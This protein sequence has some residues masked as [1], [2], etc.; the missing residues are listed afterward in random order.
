MSPPSRRSGFQSIMLGLLL[1]MA[2]SASVVAAAEL[3]TRIA[4]PSGMN[5]QIVVTMDK[6][7]IAK[8]NGLY[9]QFLPFQYGPPMMEALAAGSLDIV[10][11]SMMPVASYASKIP[12]DI[13]VVAIVNTSSHALMVA[14]DSDVNGPASLTGK[15][16]GVSF[17]SDSH[18]DTLIW[19]RENGL[20]GKVSLINIQP[21]DLATSLSNKSV[22]AIVI[23]QPQVLRLQQQSEAKII[24]SW[25]LDYISI[26]KVKFIKEH[27]EEMRKYLSALRDSAFFMVKNPEQSASWFADYLRTDRAIIE[28][29]A[30]EDPRH[31]VTDI[32]QIDLSVKSIDRQMIE[33]KLREA[34]EEKLI[35]ERVDPDL[36]MP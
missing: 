6:A 21:G 22:D 16:V 3:P 1:S 30:K 12:G 26:A 14:K 15:K 8:A 19:L 5:G 33:I 17:G 31:L 28:E 7:N 11:T 13:K 24:K 35:R 20:T 10:V 25:S 36:L 4:F 18:L 27:P 9:A 34:Y 32:S 2:S 23:R 29:A